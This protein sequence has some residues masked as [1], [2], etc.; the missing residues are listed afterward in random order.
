MNILY[1]GFERDIGMGFLICILMGVSVLCAIAFIEMIKEHEF[2]GAAIAGLVCIILCFSA[3]FLYETQGNIPIIKAT[4]DNSYSWKQL[5]SEYKLR[6]TEGQIYTFEVL[7]VN[8]NEWHKVIKE[9]Q[10][11]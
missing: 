6:S 1:Y 5:N 9:H 2:N 4:I 8:T 7:N 3:I 10:G 11:E